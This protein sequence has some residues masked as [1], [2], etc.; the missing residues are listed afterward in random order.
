MLR[1]YDVNRGKTV[2]ICYLF[3]SFFIFIP[4]LSICL[5]LKPFKENLIMSYF[6][7]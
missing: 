7:V 4:M 5:F 6:T 3:I 1:T 2:D